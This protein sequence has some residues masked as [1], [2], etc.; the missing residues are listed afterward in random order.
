MEKF[1]STWVLT[2][3]I[4]SVKNW[5]IY[6]KQFQFKMYGK[7]KITEYNYLRITNHHDA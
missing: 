1:L 7:G 4:P 6:N 2:V 5:M 3:Q